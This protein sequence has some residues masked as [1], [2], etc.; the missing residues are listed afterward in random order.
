MNNSNENLALAN[1]IT[2]RVNP[3]DARI[4]A[5]KANISGDDQNNK[6]QQRGRI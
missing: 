4:A 2:L 5:N 3:A 6:E 1:K